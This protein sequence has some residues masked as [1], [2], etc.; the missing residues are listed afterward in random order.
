MATWEEIIYYE[1]KIANDIVDYYGECWMLQDE[2]IVYIAVIKDEKVT[3]K[4]CFYLEMGVNRSDGFGTDP[5]S[6]EDLPA[7]CELQKPKREQ[8]DLSALEF[9]KA[10]DIASYKLI[11]KPA[12]EVEPHNI[13]DHKIRP[14]VGG[15][16]ISNHKFKRKAGTL[17]AFMKLKGFDDFVYF[18][19]NFHVLSHSSDLIENDLICQ[20]HN[21]DQDYENIV[22]IL[23]CGKYGNDP[24]TGATLDFAI[25]Q[26]IQKSAAI[27][28]VFRKDVFITNGFVWSEET[29]DRQAPTI[30]GIASPEYGQIVRINGKSSGRS[31]AVHIRSLNAMVRIRNAYSRKEKMI[32]KKQILLPK[33]SISGDSGAVL[34]DVKTNKV[35]GLVHSGDSLNLSVANNIDHIF[36]QKHL[37]NRQIIKLE[38]KEFIT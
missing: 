8:V 20:P 9:H 12:S 18:I 22:G 32:F 11:L 29:I 1:E 7:I 17:G 15:L 25:G 19:S 27:D 37:Y 34:I 5:V 38:T 4:S 28:R 3:T 35:V 13:S 6:I 10:D 30:E 26:I 31:N 14:M 21:F 33:I 16:S 36:N 2:T 24:S 23:R